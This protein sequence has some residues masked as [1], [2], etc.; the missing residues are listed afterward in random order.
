MTELLVLVNGLPGSGKSTVGRALAAEL[1]AQFLAKDV[2]KEALADCVDDAAGVAALGGVAMEAVW[3]L[4]R[5]VP[6]TVVVDSWWFRP[7]DLHFAR[8]GLDRCAADRAVEV[9]CDVPAE[10]A[11]HR[12]AT[13]RR[14]AFYQDEQ[15]LAEHWDTWAAHAAPLALTPTV[16]VDTGGPVDS[17]RLAERVLTAAGRT[18]AGA[19]PPR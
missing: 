6:G 18:P 2:V 12:Y 15:R 3:A 4:A 10:T 19:F 1:G 5:A 11:R 13:R 7:R 17:V 8:A 9:W 14:P 16:W